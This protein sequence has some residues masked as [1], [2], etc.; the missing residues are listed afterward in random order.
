VNWRGPTERTY[1]TLAGLLDA[2]ISHIPF[3]NFDVLLGR[4]V[5]LDLEGL[6]SKLVRCR[7]C[8][9]CFEHATLFA[10]VLERLGFEPVSHAARVTVFQPL[11]EAARTHMFLSVEL[12]GARFVIDPGFGP[13]GSNL[14]VLLD[15]VSAPVD[16]STHRMSREGDLWVMHA[17]RDGVEI[18]AW[19]ST[20][21]IQY[22]V[23]FEMAN[24][25]T[26][27]HPT[28]RFVNGILA[29]AVTTEGRVNVMNRDVTV[30][31]GRTAEKS[32]LPDRL[33][34]R[35]LLAQHF[36]FDLPE[37]ETMRVPSVPDWR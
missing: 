36:G 37:A 21:E 16:R 6:Q 22:P 8:G 5:R 27:T 34:L 1:A 25:F 30:L 2:H 14:P 15:D 11:W 3:E 7:R 31:R 24:H 18:P 26:A 10:A 19:V 35:V 32:T 12:E 4:P 17:T 28:S 20:L 13:F 23:D 33:A 9:Y 29:S